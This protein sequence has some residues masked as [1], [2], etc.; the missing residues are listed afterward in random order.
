MEEGFDKL[1]INPWIELP[2]NKP[3]LYQLAGVPTTNYNL[4]L[5]GKALLARREGHT[6]FFV[7][8]HGIVDFE[9]LKTDLE[10]DKDLIKGFYLF[11]P[12]KFI[13]FISIIDDL[14]LLYIHNNS[15]PIIFISG[16]FEFLVKNPTNTKNLGLMA[17][18]L[19]LLGDYKIPIFVTNEMRIAQDYGSP[20]LS[21]FI[22]TFFTKVF[23][24]EMEGKEL[25]IL[26]YNY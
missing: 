18:V 4:L 3:G 21:F 17:Y 1:I 8:N 6:I 12:K 20:F 16:I 9:R 11:T 22:P 19:G 24:V 10:N 7:D 2:N 25:N 15:R 13:D 26:T 14:D 5:Y 23:I